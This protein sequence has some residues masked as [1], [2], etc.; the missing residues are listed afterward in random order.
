VDV[1]AKTVAARVEPS[2]ALIGGDVEFN[3]DTSDVIGHLELESVAD[4]VEVR[5]QLG[6][7]GPGSAV[8]GGPAFAASP[9]AAAAPTAGGQSSALNAGEFAVKQLAGFGDPAPGIV[10]T[11]QYGWRVYQRR[12]VLRTEELAARREKDEAWETL[13]V[14]KAQLGRQSWRDNVNDSIVERPLHR[15]IEADGK[16]AGIKGERDRLD[17]DHEGRAGQFDAQIAAVEAECEPFRAQEL[18]ARSAF[19]QVNTESKRLAAKIKRS[20]IELRNIRELIEK[21]QK[22]YADLQKPKEER[23]RILKEIAD[24]DHRQPPIVERLGAE[25]RELEAL[26]APY[27]AAKKALADVQQALAQKNEI[28]VGFRRQKDTAKKEHDLAVESLEGKARGE[29]DQ[30]QKAWMA[31][32]EVVF[33]NRLFKSDALKALAKEAEQ[34]SRLYFDAQARHDLYE[35]AL[36]AHDPD[37]Y[38]S[39]RK[40]AMAGA[41]GIGVLILIIL[42]S[43]V[44]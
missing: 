36:L 42:I 21:R 38:D 19:D 18:K 41:V 43:V 1:R 8:R 26:A 37:V 35:R 14:A 22:D 25:R 31:V 23:E 2:A 15:A 24:I 29:S 28:I 4:D 33:V 39:A 10:G 13:N 11:L 32:G 44:V 12:G 34:K 5:P 40:Y 27:E 9:P 3:D 30:A 6:E 20:E 16:L 17:A 7:P